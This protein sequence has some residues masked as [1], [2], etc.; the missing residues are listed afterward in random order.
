MQRSESRWL[1]PSFISWRA[2]PFQLVSVR[3]FSILCSFRFCTWCFALCAFSCSEVHVVSSTVIFRFSFAKILAWLIVERCIQTTDICI[4]LVCFSTQSR[5]VSGR[6]W[7]CY[8]IKAV[9][10]AAC[11]VEAWNCSAFSVLLLLYSINVTMIFG[12]LQ[13]GIQQAAQTWSFP[14]NAKF[15]E[16]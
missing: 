7:R 14:Q 1:I 12:S 8:E 5:V 6:M 10:S 11:F 15:P 2:V 3:F 13:T 16:F 4:L 9:T